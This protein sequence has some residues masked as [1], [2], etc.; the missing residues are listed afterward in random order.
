[1]KKKKKKKKGVCFI[2]VFFSQ[3]TNKHRQT[4]TQRAQYR[5]PPKEN[6]PYRQLQLEI[7]TQED[8]KRKEFYPSAFGAVYQPLFSWTLDI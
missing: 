8:E 1:M 3:S 2:L 5:T 4:I 6:N 7:F